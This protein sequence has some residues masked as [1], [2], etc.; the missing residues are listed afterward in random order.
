MDEDTFRMQV[1]EETDNEESMKEMPETISSSKEKKKVN[2][3]F[4]YCPK[5]LEQR[6]KGINEK[7]LLKCCVCNGDLIE[8]EIAVEVD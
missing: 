5:C 6:I 8:K 4:Y 7:F 2:V 3:T 1:N